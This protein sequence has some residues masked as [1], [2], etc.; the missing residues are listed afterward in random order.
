MPSERTESPLTWPTSAP[1]GVD[2]DRL[3]QHVVAQARAHAVGAV[4]LRVDGLL[5]VRGAH[6]L[7][8]FAPRPVVRLLQQVDDGAHLGGDALGVAREARGVLDDA[9]DRGA[10]ERQQALAARPWRR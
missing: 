9:A 1:C 2:E 6:Q 8:R 3:A 10:V 4:D 7:R 5:D